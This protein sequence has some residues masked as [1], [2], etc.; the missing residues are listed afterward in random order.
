MSDWKDLV[1]LCDPYLTLVDHTRSFGLGVNPTD[2]DRRALQLQDTKESLV[3]VCPPV[4]PQGRKQIRG[5]EREG[6]RR[7]TASKL[8]QQR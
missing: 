5:H 6:T 2:L 7:I 3:I 1:R 4:P 8:W